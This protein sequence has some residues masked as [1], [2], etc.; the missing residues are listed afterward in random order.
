[1]AYSQ[2]PV[3]EDAVITITNDGNGSQ[4]NCTYH[5]RL[6]NARHPSAVF[7]LATW[8]HMVRA[9]NRWRIKQGDQVLFTTRQVCEAA[10]LLDAYYQDHL[11]EL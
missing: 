4:C 6:A 9:Y 3:V 1:M 2:D 7:R 5:E 8:R 11:G 10:R